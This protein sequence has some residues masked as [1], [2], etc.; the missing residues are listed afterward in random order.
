TWCTRRAARDDRAFVATEAV[1][2]R[3]AEAI[4]TGS[5]EL[6]FTG[7][8]PT[9]RRDLTALV[10]LAHAGGAERITLETNATLVEVARAA[11]LRDAGL[12][13]AR[14]NT[15]AFGDACDALTRDPG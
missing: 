3:I 9:M 4:A 15:P 12:E 14:V 2:A 8:E 6:T 11:E 5:R 1:R 13:V 10:A 7:G